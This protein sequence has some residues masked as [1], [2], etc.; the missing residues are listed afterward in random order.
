MFEKLRAILDRAYARSRGTGLAHI[1]DEACAELSRLE[2]REASSFF[3]WGLDYEIEGWAIAA[4][5][6]RAWE[7]LREAYLRR[8]RSDEIGLLPETL[9]PIIPADAGVW[10]PLGVHVR[11]CAG[12]NLWGDVF[13]RNSK[14]EWDFVPPAGK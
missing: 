10:H 3:L 4:S 11:E 7:L 9:Q 14:G 5:K 13:T 1:M 8:Y 2:K 12:T 6:Q